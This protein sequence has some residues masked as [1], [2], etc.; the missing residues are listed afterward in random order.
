VAQALE[1]LVVLEQKVVMSFQ[2]GQRQQVQV[3]LAIMQVVVLV[4]LL[5]ILL[6][7]EVVMVAVVRVTI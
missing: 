4:V 3:V 2:H 6:H 7:Q 1:I 5:K